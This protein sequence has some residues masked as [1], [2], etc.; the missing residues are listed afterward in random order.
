MK[1]A[2]LTDLTKCIGCESC[3]WACK[4][5]NELPRDDGAA[6]LSA[7][8]WTRVEKVNGV[9][10]RRQCMHCE[11]PACASVCPVGA[12]HKTQEGPVVYDEDKC[13][14]CRYC[15]IGCP[16]G[17]PK[18]EWSKN[19]PRV[20]KCIMCHDKAVSKGQQPACTQACP[21]GATIF[22][23]RDALLKEAHRRIRENPDRYVDHVYG[24]VEAGGTSVLYLSAVP[25]ETLGFKTKVRTDP[26]PALTWN[27]LHKLPNVVSVAGVGL[28]GIYWVIRRRQTLAHLHAEAVRAKRAENAPGEGD[29]EDT[30]RN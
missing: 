3:A 5:I 18:Y 12:L 16:F 20:Q 13:I 23:D 7:T 30:D 14:G 19:V 11:D 21:T 2:I 4:E 29:F 17:I 6:T 22:G 8:T 28:V 1:A 10:V 26:Y 15:M 9:N 27:V 25:F 24:E